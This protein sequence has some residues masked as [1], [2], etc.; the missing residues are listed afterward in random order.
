[1]TNYAEDL[2]KVAT[3]SKEGDEVII[4]SSEEESGGLVEFHD[5]V[6]GNVIYKL[7]KIPQYGGQPEFVGFYENPAE[8]VDEAHSWT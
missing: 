2:M 3:I 1:M 7:S 5:T 6:N 8:M 4:A